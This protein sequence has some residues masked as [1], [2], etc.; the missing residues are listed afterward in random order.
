[1]CQYTGQPAHCC[2]GKKQL[3]F[4]LKADVMVDISGIVSLYIAPAT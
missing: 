4:D 3:T 1:M 2:A